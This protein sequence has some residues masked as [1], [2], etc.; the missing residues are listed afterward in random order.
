MMNDLIKVN[1]D[2]EQPT[3]S[4]RELHNAL[5]IN[6]KYQN[7]GYVHS[8]TIDIVRSNGMSDVKMQT[9]WTQK[10]R[11]FLYELLKKEG[12]MPLIEAA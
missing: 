6:S 12:Y 8:R 7:Q 3:V 11:L 2:T 10:G 1:Y 9:E 4:A 5:G